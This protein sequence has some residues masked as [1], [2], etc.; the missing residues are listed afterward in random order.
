LAISVNW[1]TKIIN[2]PQADLTPLGGNVYELDLDTF[3]L[4]LKDL[5]D[6]EEGIWADDTHNHTTETVLAGITYARFVEIINGYT[7]TFEDGQ[8]IVSAVGANSNLAD[9]MNLN[10]VSLRTANSA[11]LIV[12][13]GAGGDATEAKQDQIINAISTVSTD[14]TEA[15]GLLYKNYKLTDPLYATFGNYRR[16]TSAVIRTYPTAVDL[17]NGTNAIGTYSVTASYFDNG[18]MHEYYVE[19]A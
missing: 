3:R 9:V 8:Y 16:M 11:G 10:Q 5:E 15:L 1:G 14:L 6:N 13:A 12:V 19:D 2:V 4:A 18:D 7:V 17:G